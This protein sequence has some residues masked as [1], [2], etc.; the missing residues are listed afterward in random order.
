MSQPSILIDRENEI[1]RYEDDLKAFKTDESK[2]EAQLKTLNEKFGQ[3][4]MQSDSEDQKI[5]K[6]I[7]KLKSK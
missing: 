3:I 2:N 4:V 5:F 6:M 1:R 7:Q